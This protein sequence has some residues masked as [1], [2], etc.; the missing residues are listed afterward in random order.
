LASDRY[1]SFLTLRD[2]GV[3]TLPRALRDKLHADEAGVQLEITE[4]ADGVFELRPVVPVPAQQR[5]FWT[6]RWQAM[7]RDADADIEAGRA[8][9]F[10]DV[11]GF[12]DDL[13]R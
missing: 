9:R 5:W 11:D 13:D 7:E 6:D 1:H 12:L 10:D 3:V 2:R 8:E 4:R